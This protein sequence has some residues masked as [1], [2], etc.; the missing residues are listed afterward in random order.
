MSEQQ[1]WA[2]TPNTAAQQHMP[3]NN[4]PPHVPHMQHPPQWYPP[5]PPYVTPQWRSDP[6]SPDGATAV[7]APLR[8]RRLGK[9]VVA[10]VAA[11]ALSIA[12]AV[13]G[14]V[15]ALELRPATATSTVVTAQNSS[16][17]STGTANLADVAAAVRPSVVSI[18]TGSA[19][20]SGVII[21][22]DGSILTNNHVVATAR[23]TTV[24]I[25][26]SDGK[27]GTAAIVGTDPGTDLA[28]IK[29]TGGG[30]YTPLAFADSSAVKV[31][32]TVLAIGSPLGLESS[33]TSGIVSALNREIDEGSDSGGQGGQGTRGTQATAGA[34]I[35][36]AIQTDAAINPGNSGGALV[37]TAGQLIGINTA[38]ASTSETAGN[39]GVGF[40]ISSNTAKTVAQQLLS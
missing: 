33:V 32:D 34:K 9:G 7:P 25:T 38:I 12:S 40:A 17:S 15:A 19:V 18:N 5:S 20:G 26:F 10:V 16:G 4:V 13:G 29:L 39:I 37:N 6:T 23:G 22:T 3:T 31:G 2:Q 14:G 30:T 35:T 24:Q 21:T 11:A 28:V 8:S 36:G 1:G 27:S